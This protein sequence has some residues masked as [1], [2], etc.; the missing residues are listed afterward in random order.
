MDIYTELF[1]T[2]MDFRN[3]VEKYVIQHH[4]TLE[5]ALKHKM[6]HNYGDYIL[7]KVDKNA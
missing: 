2:N 3:Y 7:E 1:N 6:V 5:E 4:I